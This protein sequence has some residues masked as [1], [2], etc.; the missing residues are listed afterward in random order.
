MYHYYCCA[1]GRYLGSHDIITTPPLQVTDLAARESFLKQ[2]I[3]NYVLA[4]CEV[5][6]KDL[7][8]LSL[9]G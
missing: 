3:K 6:H 4:G 7:S 9:G 1:G 2:A 5:P 8:K